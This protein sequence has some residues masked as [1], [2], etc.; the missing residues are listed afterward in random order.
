MER[1]ACTMP[2][3]DGQNFK[4]VKSTGAMVRSFYKAGFASPGGGGI[5]KVPTV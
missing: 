5:N 1:I 2:N 3:Q 4:L